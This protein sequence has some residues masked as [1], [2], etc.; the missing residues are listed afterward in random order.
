MNDWL[1]NK[2]NQQM[3]DYRYYHQHDTMND[4]LTNKLNQQMLDYR[5]YHQHDIYWTKRKGYIIDKRTNEVI[6]YE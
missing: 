4:W 2:L 3:L 1:T 6:T 5:Y